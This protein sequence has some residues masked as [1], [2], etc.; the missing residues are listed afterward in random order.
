[1]TNQTEI[2]YKSELDGVIEEKTQ[3]KD[4]RQMLEANVMRETWR[5]NELIDR[6]DD[7]IAKTSF[8]KYDFLYD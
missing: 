4:R 5:I 2:P 1:M 7:V 8:Y 3:W 6:D